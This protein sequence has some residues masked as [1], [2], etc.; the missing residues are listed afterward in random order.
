MNEKMRI[1]DDYRPSGDKWIGHI[2]VHWRSTSLGVISKRKSIR[3]R[4][5]LPLLSV[6]REKGVVLRTSLSQEE[7]YNF[8]PDDLSNY[9]V[10]SEGDLVVNKMKAWQGSV[11]IALQDGIVSPAYYIFELEEIKKKYAHR[12]LR[13]RLY[14][15]FF[16]RASDGVRIG[17][18][19]LGI[20]AMKRIPVVIPPP[21]EQDAISRYLDDVDRRI[22]RFVRNRRRLIEV[23]N[24]QKQAIIN[25]AVT[26]GLDPNVPLKPSGVDW[27]GDIPEHWEIVKLKYLSRIRYGLGQ[28]PKEV[29]DGLPFIRATN[30]KSGQIV[31][32]NLVYVDPEDVPDNRN[33]ILRNKEIVVVRSGAL[34]AD[35]AL[36]PESYD[37]AVVGYDMVL[38]V[39]AALPEFVANSLLSPYMLHDQL[40]ILRSRA[41]QPHLNAEELGNVLVALPPFN[42]QARIVKYI[43]QET[44]LLQG[45]ISRAQ[46]EIDLIREYRTRLI[47]DV[48]TGKV[49]VR[50]LAP[51]RGSGGLE[52]KLDELEPL[53]EVVSEPGEEALAEEV[54]YAD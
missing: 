44:S 31:E 39:K 33:A 43:F 17:Q 23:L 38:T 26:R 48:V 8:V 14:A 41:A 6:L 3:N 30:V 4:S 22:A 46:R 53:D 10:T 34:T 28:P 40:Y 9:Q 19:D 54:S 49:D 47:S 29:K 13:S 45:L 15:D 2:P 12:L 36:I 24:E 21:E 27:L 5:D 35:S 11:G 18:W 52:E 1:Y 32:R 7:N 20:Q 25:R 50:H 37:G 42:E 51:A 16:G